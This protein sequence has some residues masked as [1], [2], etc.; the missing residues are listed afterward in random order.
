[1]SVDHLV[2][3]VYTAGGG[4]ANQVWSDM[5]Q[6]ML[7]VPV[8]RSPADEAAYGAALLASQE[9]INRLH[10]ANTLEPR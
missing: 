10:A 2:M 6:Q 5:R 7:G 8:I 4:A 9:K 3:Q 1:M